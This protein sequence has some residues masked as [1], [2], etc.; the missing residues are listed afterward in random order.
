MRSIN[1]IRLLIFALAF[2]EGFSTA[3]YSDKKQ[4]VGWIEYVNIYPENLKI[5]AKLDTGAK[6][7]SLNAVNIVEFKRGGEVFVRFDITNWKGR[8]ETIEAKVIRIAK[9]KRHKSETEQRPVIRL[10]ICLGKVYREVEVNL[11]NRSNFLYQ[12]LIGRSFL[13]GEFAVDPARTFTIKTD[14]RKDLL[15]E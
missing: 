5:K 9:I 10:G 6:N 12:L 2:L 15:D 8:T 7:S 11:V 13:K 1:I 4:V 3:V 14:C